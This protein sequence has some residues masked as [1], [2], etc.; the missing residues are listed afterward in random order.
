MYTGTYL[1]IQLDNCSATLYAPCTLVQRLGA[2]TYEHNIISACSHSVFLPV[3]Q[4]V[5]R[6]TVKQGQKK[7]KGEREARSEPRTSCTSNYIGFLDQWIE[8]DIC[9]VLFSFFE[10]P[11]P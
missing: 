2:V 4:T 5:V 9:Y 8:T 6:R 3:T 7:R 1:P 10:S 11:S